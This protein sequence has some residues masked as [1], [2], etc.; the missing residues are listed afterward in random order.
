MTMTNAKINTIQLQAIQHKGET[1][2][3]I[4]VDGEVVNSGLT[5]DF[6]SLVSSAQGWGD[7]FILTCSCGEASCIGLSEDD[8]IKGTQTD[9]TIK[10]HITEPK[11]ERTFVFEKKQY[12]SAILEFFN[13]INGTNSKNAYTLIGTFGYDEDRFNAD[14]KKI[15]AFNL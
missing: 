10:W 12:I 8:K 11:P 14:F 13:T 15:K 4:L 7:F 1:V 9:S 2:E 3:E 5:I 6:Y